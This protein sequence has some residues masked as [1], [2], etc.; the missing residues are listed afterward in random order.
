MLQTRH[1]LEVVFAAFDEVVTTLPSTYATLEAKAY[2]MD[3]MLKIA[4][5]G[6]ANRN[7]IVTSSLDYIREVILFLIV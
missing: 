1:E 6:H 4:A 3:F 7:E 5:E 2:L